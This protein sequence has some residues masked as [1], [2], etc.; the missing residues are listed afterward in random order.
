MLKR[1]YR[2]IAAVHLPADHAAAPRTDR[3]AEVIPLTVLPF[4][5]PGP[6]PHGKCL[7]DGIAE[8]MINALSS[9]STL[10]VLPRSTVWRVKD[11]AQQPEEA[12]CAL[13]VRPVLAGRALPCGETVL[14]RIELTDVVAQR[15]LWGT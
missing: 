11:Q 2:C 8:S 14:V 9:L 12:G 5:N 7:S 13:G 3:P 15:Q 6:D 4:I 10:R 1:S